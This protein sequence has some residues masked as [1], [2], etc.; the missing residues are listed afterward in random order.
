MV[1]PDSAGCKIPPY[2]EI[3]L[4]CVVSVGLAVYTPPKVD[5]NTGIIFDATG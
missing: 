5:W 4:G 2:R 1:P 3:G